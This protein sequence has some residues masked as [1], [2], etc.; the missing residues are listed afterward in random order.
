MYTHFRKR[1]P[2][3]A[4]VRINERIIA[5]A[6]KTPE[7]HPP[8]EEGPSSGAEIGDEEN[9][10]SE[11]GNQGKLLMDAT[12]A[13]ADIAY[14]TD[15]KLLNQ[16]REKN[17]AIIDVLHEARGNGRKTPR[18]YR[19]KAR[20]KFLSAAKS[21]KLGGKKL[22][23]AIRAQLGFVRR[24]LGHIEALSREVGLEVLSPRQYKDLL[25][26]S[27]VQHRQQ[28]WMYDNTFFGAGMGGDWIEKSIHLPNQKLYPRLAF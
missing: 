26:I 11:P 21:K 10:S 18:T 7:E 8:E 16:A 13:P 14:P 22:R 25:V 15:L 4:L 23:K 20:K 28:Q 9:D 5:L 12:C 1:F 3:E 19:V 17:K 24:D 2:A 27:E 6:R